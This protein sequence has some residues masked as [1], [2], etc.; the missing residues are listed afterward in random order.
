MIAWTAHGAAAK[1][2]PS[3]RL[4]ER[5]NYDI[6]SHPTEI[7]FGVSSLDSGQLKLTYDYRT[8]GN[9]RSVGR[10]VKKVQQTE[11]TNYQVD[12]T[13]NRAGA[14]LSQTY[15]AASPLTTRRVVTHTFD[16]AGRLRS[17]ST[18]GASVTNI[19]YAAHGA[20]AQQLRGARRHAVNDTQP[21]APSLQT[22]THARQ[23]ARVHQAL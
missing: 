23:A 8:T 9:K 3:D 11:G 6:R 22:D 12:A 15:P 18:A 19:E 16:G 2:R 14:I 21:C 13:Y 10:V 4:R 7:G 5:T 17:L 1:L 20:L